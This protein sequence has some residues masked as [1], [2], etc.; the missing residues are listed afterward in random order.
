MLFENAVDLFDQC[1]RGV[2]IVAA[3]IVLVDRN[4]LHLRFHARLCVLSNAE[5]GSAVQNDGDSNK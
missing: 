3:D 2:V 4:F 5:Q 1:D